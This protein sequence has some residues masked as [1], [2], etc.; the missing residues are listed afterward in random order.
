MAGGVVGRGQPGDQA[1]AALHVVTAGSG[2]PRIDLGEGGEAGCLESSGG[3][4]TGV[5]G[6]GRGVDV[7]QHPAGVHR[8][9]LP[10]SGSRWGG[11]GPITRGNGRRRG[12][13]AMAEGCWI[14]AQAERADATRRRHRSAP[15]C[16]CSPSPYR[17]RSSAAVRPTMP[18]GR[19]APP[20]RWPTSP[21]PSTPCRGSGPCRRRSEPARVPMWSEALAVQRT[22][23]DDAVTRADV[24]LVSLGAVDPAIATVAR[25]A[26]AHLAGLGGIRS[27]T[28]SS[29][30]DVPWTDPFAPVDRRDAPG[31]G[32]R[33]SGDRR[34]RARQPAH[35]P[36]PARPVEGSRRDAGR[37]DGR[38]VGLGRAS[39][40]ADREPDQPAGR[41]SG[42][43]GGLPRRLAA[44]AHRR[45]PQRGAA[46]RRHPDRAGRRRG[47]RWRRPEPA[48]D[49]ARRRCGPPAGPARG[50]G[51]PGHG[52]PR[53]PSTPWRRPRGSPAPPTSSSRAR[54]SSSPW[55]WRWRRLDPS[56][57]PCGSSP[58]PPTTWPPS[59]CPSSSTRSVS[60][61][62]TTR[63][64]PPRSSPSRSGPTMRSGSWPTRSTP[65][66]RS[67][68]TSPPSSPC[69][70][71]RAS[72]TCT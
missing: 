72:A 32:V 17:R 40:R 4:R 2:G 52:G 55:P 69:C 24:A 34:A 12:I 16:C 36:R 29:A 15:R 20:S 57:A 42:L 50:R 26:R 10:G 45:A 27:Q 23:T 14:A 56:P 9:S 3:L 44:G 8:P 46:G 66:S 1:A 11:P 39:Q 60:R 33:R 63:T 28:D 71:R 30:S 41:R 70:S 5:E 54:R 62:T 58:T 65:C 19:P 31:G 68:S 13:A 38:G 7:G 43:P 48:L 49:V 61:S 51:D 67:P 53:W 21:P 37:A 35:R 18:I 59:G 22:I 47:D 25:S 64:W 6:R